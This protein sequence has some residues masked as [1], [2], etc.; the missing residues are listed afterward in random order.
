MIAVIDTDSCATAAGAS[1]SLA[2]AEEGRA[3]LAEGDSTA[4]KAQ[5][6]VIV[7]QPDGRDIACAVP[8]PESSLHVGSA[9]EPD[10]KAREGASRTDARCA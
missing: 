6:V 4:S 7:L 3:G 8:M 10:S 1:P 2:L 9:R 5:D